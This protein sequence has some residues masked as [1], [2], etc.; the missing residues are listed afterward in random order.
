MLSEFKI[1]TP[2]KPGKKIIMLF[3]LLMAVMLLTV[4]IFYFTKI[5]QAA[6]SQSLPTEV[7]IEK[8]LSTRQIADLLER[9][10]IINSPWAFILYVKLS[11][12]QGRVLAG[13]YT[14]DPRMSTVE[15]VDIL[16]AGKITSKEKR[17][18]VIEGLSI[19]EIAAYLEARN[20]FLAVE[21]EAAAANNEGY[22]FPDT[23][24]L[25]K[26]AVVAE[27][28]SKMLDN[29]KKKTQDLKVTKDSIILASIIEKEVGR[30][31]DNLSP[32]DLTAM[33]RE[34][35]FVASVFLNRLKLGMPLQSDA[36]VNYI[37]GK[38]DRQVSL[39]DTKIKS[40]YNTYLV[41]GL[42]EAPIGNP[43]LD[44]IL[45]ALDPAES[46]YLYFLNAPDGTAYFAKTV[47]EHNDNRVKYL[48]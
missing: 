22:L 44:A 23:Y 31:G 26:D 39:A 13:D 5:N 11:K 33:Q 1:E 29:F 7:T 34:R 41:K 27:L 38:K 30:T 15:I 48:D 42:P 20:I 10:N 3:L 9:E 4:L 24:L 28:V 18:T 37:T 8:G 40:P 35:R 14:L 25:S 2:E 19:R 43:G 16:T 47:E 12:A 32:E 36:T 17:V 45:A 46:D 6:S 21:F